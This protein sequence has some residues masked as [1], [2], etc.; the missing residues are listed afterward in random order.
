MFRK[1]KS[2]NWI[3]NA[4]ESIY[5]KWISSKSAIFNWIF[6][7]LRNFPMFWVTATD[8]EGFDT[9]KIIIRIPYLT[10]YDAQHL[11]RMLVNAGYITEHGL[12]DRGL[13][14]AWPS[15]FKNG[16]IDER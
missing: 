9:N 15:R 12:W 14:G 2:M 10:Y 1:I 6:P 16:E 4:M 3:N 5:W 8:H 7:K 11:D 13:G